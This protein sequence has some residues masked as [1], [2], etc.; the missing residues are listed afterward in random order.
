[1]KTRLFIF[2]FFPLILWSQNFS[3][4]KIETLKKQIDAKDAYEKLGQKKLLSLCGELYTLSKDAGYKRGMLEALLDYALIYGNGS[5]TDSA[6][7]S[8]AEALPLAEE[9]KNY[10]YYSFL[11]QIKARALAEAGNFDEA[12][13]SFSRAL[14]GVDQIKYEDTLHFRK[15]LIYSDLQDYAILADEAYPNAGYKDST[16]Y[17][18]KKSYSEIQKAPNSFKAKNKA[19]GQIVRMLG[20]AYHQNGNHK[21]ANVYYDQAEKILAA[22]GDKRFIAGLYAFRGNQEFEQGN[23]QKALEYWNKTMQLSKGN[24]FPRLL[25]IIYPKII[26]YYKKVNDYKMQA[27]YLEKSKKLTDSL[28]LI[29]QS[30]LITQGKIDKKAVTVQKQKSS[31]L[32]LPVLIILLI[33]FAI[34][35]IYFYRKKLQKRQFSAEQ[36][37]KYK[38]DNASAGDKLLLLLE[39]AKR[40]DKHL[41]VVFQNAFPELYRKLLEFP[42]LTPLDLEMCVYLKLNI[43]TKE[44][45]NYMRTSI[46]SV[47]SRKYRLRKKLNIPQDTSLYIWINKL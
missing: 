28:T 20:T 42:E 33:L 4:Q 41:L 8:I 35:I 18:A 37:D 32:F 17:F 11:L 6:L 9:L 5:D 43:Q 31:S 24:N 40:N 3:K 29:D 38:E 2:L 1:M 46:N 45:A 26:E 14:K 7:K 16:L 30:A 21:E 13:I 47:D 10:E 22:E 36:P 19:L 12:R 15:A 23:D 34:I 25:I 39:M 27:Y 44:I